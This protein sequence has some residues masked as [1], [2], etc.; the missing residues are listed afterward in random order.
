MFLGDMPLVPLGAA[1][2]LL[3][4]LGQ[5]ADGAEYLCRGRPAH[6]VAFAARLY[7]MVAGLEGEAGARR[8]LRESHAAIQLDTEDEGSIHDVDKP[9]D[10]VRGMNLASSQPSGSTGT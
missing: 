1:D 5:G 2:R 8:L 7:A 6:P 9:H 10:L 3:T 4:L